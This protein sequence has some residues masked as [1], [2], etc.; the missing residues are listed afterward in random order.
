MSDHLLFSY[1][2]LRLPEVQ[3]A[4]FGR[5]VQG[6]AD[7]MLGWQQRMIEITDA[8]VIAKSGTRWHPLVEPSANPLDAVEGMVFAISVADLASADAYEVDYQ[9]RAVHLRSGRQAW[10]YGAPGA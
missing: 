6:E 2:T 1:G 10:F 5:L 8:D 7:A 4:L 9:R 3:M